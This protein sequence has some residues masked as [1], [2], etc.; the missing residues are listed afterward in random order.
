MGLRV[1]SKEGECIH[2]KHSMFVLQIISI[3]CAHVQQP[4][5]LDCL[6]ASDKKLDRGLGMRLP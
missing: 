1:D 3:P 6:S 4:F 5:L 2:V